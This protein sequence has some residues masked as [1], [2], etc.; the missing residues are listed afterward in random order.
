[1]PF[2]DPLFFW[3]P[4]RP[5]GAYPFLRGGTKKGKKLPP[6]SKGGSRRMGGVNKR[7]RG[8]VA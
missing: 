2:F 7:G 1:V 8:R 5:L 4:L 3:Q 6:F